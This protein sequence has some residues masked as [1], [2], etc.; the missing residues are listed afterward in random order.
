[1]VHLLPLPG[2]PRAALP[3]D[4]G[5]VLARAE[6]DA[7]AL[8]GGG[9]HGLLVENFGD[10]PFHPDSV[11]AETVAALALAVSTVR[12]VAQSAGAVPVGVNVLRNDAR[13]GLGIAA[14]TGARFMRV[15]VHIGSMFTDQGPLDGRAHETLRIR[16]ALVPDLLLLADVHVKHATPPAGSDLAA[17]ARDTRERGLADVLVLSGPATGAPP[18]PERLERVRAAVPDAPLW[19]GSGLT[20]DLA[21]DFFPRRGNGGSGAAEGVADGAIV[22]SSLHYD[23]VAGSGIDIERV[24]AIVSAIRGR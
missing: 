24:R 19:I 3:T 8:V 6:Q 1:M 7:R 17:T 14:A 18:G 13:A 4:M 23:G 20:P 11:P 9:V 15:N 2:S 22:G 12:R 10:A 21:P 5:E 16:R